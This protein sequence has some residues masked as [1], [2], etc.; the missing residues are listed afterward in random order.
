MIFF[1]RDKKNTK[2]ACKL[3][4]L[5]NDWKDSRIDDMKVS[6]RAEPLLG[7]VVLVSPTFL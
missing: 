4:E 1:A 3:M 2:V 7:L 6:A 5:G